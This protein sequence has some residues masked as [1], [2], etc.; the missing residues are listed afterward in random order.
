M[1]ELSLEGITVGASS[2]IRPFL[3]EI[4]SRFPADIHSI[5]VTGSALTA[6]FS[7]KH[8][9]VNSLI[10]LNDITFDFM[11]FIAPLGRKFGKK[12][13][14]A[15][16][17]MTPRYIRES[18]DV[19]PME[20]LELRMIHKTVFGK[21]VLQDVEITPAFLRLQC[22]REIK[23]RLMGLRQGYIS[24]LGDSGKISRMLAHSIT[25]C[26]PLFRAVIFLKG[27]EPPVCKSD[28]ISALAETTGV[29]SAAFE[30]VLQL[31]DKESYSALALF[32]EYYANMETMSDIINALEP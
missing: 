30:K 19:F 27:K 14:A 9:D 6:D 23:T 1:L 13:V 2:R 8:S 25:G 7:E 20:F 16:L 10:V 5:Y 21:D 11:R 31:K 28:V 29:A 4:L 18:L 32:E 26:V 24:L 3:A 15:P 17:L 12:G 22:E